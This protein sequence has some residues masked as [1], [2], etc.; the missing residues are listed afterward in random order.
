MDMEAHKLMEDWDVVKYIVK[1]YLCD[2]KQE[3][4]IYIYIHTQFV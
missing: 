3:I 4:N 2:R 1:I